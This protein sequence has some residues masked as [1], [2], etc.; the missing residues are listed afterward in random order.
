MLENLLGPDRV[1]SEELVSDM[2]T[3]CRLGGDDLRGL[4][5]VF[6]E[7]GASIL[8]EE[9]EAIRSIEK[10][11]KA[12]QK[13]RK[14]LNSA[15]PASGF[16]LRR[17]AQRNLIRE[18]VVD[19]LVGIGISEE[20][21]A[22][23]APLLDAMEQSVESLRD[24][25]L[26]NHAMSLGVPRIRSATCACD[27]RAVFRTNRYE[28]SRDDSQPYFVLNGFVAVAI[29]EMVAELNEE[30]TTHAFLLDDEQLKDMEKV[31]QRARKRMKRVKDAL[32][33]LHRSKG[34]EK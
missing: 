20:E 32:G 16:V 12:F 26:E 24:H 4:A 21:S 13:D 19:D 6:A 10:N 3:L 8:S 18:Q 34:Q 17:W 31:L 28:K 7:L 22:N 9:T 5:K 33:E 25:L 23:I 29:L 11:V 1:A 30:E 2:R 15:L 14:L 27:A